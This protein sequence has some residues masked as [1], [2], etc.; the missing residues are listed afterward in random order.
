M[1]VFVNLPEDEEGRKE[2]QKA[3]NIFQ[4]T[5]IVETIKSMDINDMS[6]KKVLNGVIEKAKEMI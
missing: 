4:A 2:F 3:A 1:N 5:I 6:K